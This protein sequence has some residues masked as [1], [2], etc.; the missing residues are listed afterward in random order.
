MRGRRLNSG[1]SFNT[2][3]RTTQAGTISAAKHFMERSLGQFDSSAWTPAQ[4]STDLWLDANDSSTITLNGSTVSQWNDKSGN[5][6]HVVQASSTSQPTYNATGFNNKPTID[7]DGSNDFLKNSSYQPS[8]ALSCFVVFN[9]DTT[10]GIFV[11]IQRSGG[12]FEISGGFGGGYTNITLTATGNINPAL[13]FDISSGGTNTDIILYV[14]HDGS[15]SSASDF[16][17]RVNGTDS[18]IVNSGALGYAAETG[19]SIGAR[20]V[21]NLAYYNGRISEFV[22]IEGQISQDN[23]Q[24]IEGYLAHKWGLTNNLPADHPYKSA[25]P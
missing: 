21:Q 22:L 11:N 15:G 17:A 1:Y 24:K 9:R 23:L 18:T 5:D 4:I 7:F 10:S 3:Q 20:A 13:G 25:A 14:T 16:S 8:G 19:T 12:I 2:D 6:R